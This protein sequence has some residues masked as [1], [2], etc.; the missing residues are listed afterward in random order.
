[1]LVAHDGI[2]WLDD[3]VDAFEAQTYE[4]LELVAVDNG[5]QDGSRERLVERLGPDRVL[6]A[7]R[8]LGFP[9]AVSM[10]LDSAVAAGSDAEWILL[11]HDDLIPEPDMVERLVAQTVDPQ[12][13]I[14][15]PKLV[16]Y[17]DPRRLQQVGMSIDITGRADS[18]LEPDEL[19]QGQRDRQRPVLYVSSAG[20]L[21]RRA[22]F[23]DLGR[24][25]RR[26]HVFRDDL[27]LCWRA[28]LRGHI[29]EVVPDAVARHVR[30]VS[31]YRRLGQTEELGGRYFAE[32]NTLATLLK[33]YGAPRLALVLPL[34][35]IVGIA[36]V[37]GFIAT[38]QVSAAW[39]TVRAWMW[40]LAHLRGTIRL[41]RAIQDGRARSDSEL[42]PLFARI[43]PR[44]RSY[45]EA[46]ADRLAGG[47]VEVPEP[48]RDDLEEEPS[49]IRIVRAAR[50]HPVLVMA[51]ALGALGL[52]V[53]VPFLRSGAIR[54]GELAP[55]PASPFTFLETYASGWHDIGGL[56]TSAAPSPA[57]A[58]LGFFGLLTLGNEWLA[59]RLLLFGALPLAWV[60]ALRAGQLVSGTTVPRAVAATA[61]ALSPPAM[62]ALITGR[63]GGLVAVVMLPALALVGVRLADVHRPPANAWR[64]TAGAAIL[65]AVL[66]AFEP[67]A[68][69]LIVVAVALGLIAIAA[70]DAPAEA[71]RSASIR[72]LL[73]AAGAFV[74]LLP[75]GFALVGPGSPVLGGFT[76]TD[77]AP[78]PFLRWLL[79]VPDLDRFPG[80]IVGVAY[81]AAGLL[82]LLLGY[83][84]R[85]MLVGTLWSI[86]VLAAFGA[87]GLGRAGGDAIA[88]PGLLLLVAA[89]AY[90]TLLATA[91]TT[92]E[93]YLRSHAFGWRQIAAIV[94][95]A[96]VAAGGIGA[97]LHLIAEPWESYTVGETALPAFLNAE[98]DVPGPYRVLV[99]SDDGRRIEWDM[100]GPDGPTM[101]A[102][103]MPEQTDLATLID[104]AIEDM[105]AGVSPA[106]ASQLGIANVLYVF[107]PEGGR[108]ERLQTVLADQ[109]DLEP[110][111][112]AA[113]LVYRIAGW[114]PRASYVAPNVAVAIERR[115]ELPPDAEPVP[116]DHVAD[117]TY[118]GRVP[119]AG[120][121]LLAEPTDVGW[122]AFADGRELGARAEGR[123][124]RFS[125]PPDADGVEVRFDRQT[126]RT[127]I[128]AMQAFVTLFAVSLVLRPP[129][130]AEPPATPRSRP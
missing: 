58:V 119:G 32:R 129:S 31:N 123:L 56:A 35:L 5:S 69:P 114:V 59:P 105:T 89:L 25:D 73:A 19:D 30:A 17:D 33:C 42:A 98:Q 29:V 1:M 124:T 106:A 75:W 118:A 3:A 99:L 95:A 113:G 116:L 39:Q 72:V 108:S 74:L 14:V 53:I 20:M 126:R 22:L 49:S 36:K 130:F 67:T 103:G 18:G 38:R 46:V 8:D 101:A 110:Q 41:R 65:G 70:V 81:P 4:H 15:G 47:D 60:L 34:F 54:G 97:S 84:R 100:T 63:L 90:A 43:A 66:V 71:R 7:E 50:R 111:P 122:E 121:I 82:G 62:A 93:E 88:W 104:G 92:A 10:A 48:I 9:A 109:F 44:L 21:V 127:L 107:V 37:I 61:Y 112:V 64:A 68:A 40:N 115:G 94:A 23:D 45:G 51:I 16:S 13:G 77:A 28:W 76:A 12:L 79:L 83:R 11:L 2:G 6:I 91:F 24:L 117:D 78:S 80:L 27:D 87:W 120:T 86:V 128:V 55:W 26:Y 102:F 125:V 52:V 57:Q 96:V 85:P